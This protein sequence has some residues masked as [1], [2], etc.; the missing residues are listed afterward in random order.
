MNP[1]VLPKIARIGE[2]AMQG[3]SL[4]FRRSHYY[5]RALVLMIQGKAQSVYFQRTNMLRRNIVRK[6][7]CR[8]FSTVAEVRDSNTYLYVFGLVASLGIAGGIY[9]YSAGLQVR[10][11]KEV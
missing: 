1:A 4:L 7:Y 2:I 11:K 3:V 6:P 10:F 9:Y 5:R 8:Q